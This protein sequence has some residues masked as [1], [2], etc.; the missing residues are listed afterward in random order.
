M[1]CMMVYPVPKIVIAPHSNQPPAIIS[2][3]KP[4]HPIRLALRP[5]S[6]VANLW[7]RNVNYCQSYTEAQKKSPQAFV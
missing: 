4:S 5:A 3:A 7:K 6:S 2:R 1:R